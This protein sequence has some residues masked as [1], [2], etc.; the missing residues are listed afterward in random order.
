MDQLAADVR[1][2]VLT[3]EQRATADRYEQMGLRIK[4]ATE[5]PCAALI[6][7]CKLD[8][9]QQATVK[10]KVDARDKALAEWDRAEG[11][12]NES[13]RAAMV[14][15]WGQADETAVSVLQ[16]D[17]QRILF[18]CYTAIV[19]DVLTPPQRVTWQAYQGTLEMIMRLAP[20]LNCTPDQE[21]RV[22]E[23]MTTY[24]KDVSAIQGT[25]TEAI[26]SRNDS[27]RRAVE[28]VRAIF[29]KPAP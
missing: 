26:Q 15:E 23:T 7:E 24:Y 5:G 1:A 3:P 16:G 22:R 27:L 13:L 4:D 28:T 9:T 11:P 14:R 2:K 12:A 6:K 21:A 29:A 8:A 20:G 19:L 18:D 25:G 10:A 17:R